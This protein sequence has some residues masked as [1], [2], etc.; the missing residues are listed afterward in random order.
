MLILLHGDRRSSDR[1]LAC[2]MGK[3]VQFSNKKSID[4]EAMIP[5][6]YHQAMFHTLECM[7][8]SLTIGRLGEPPVGACSRCAIAVVKIFLCRLPMQRRRSESSQKNSKEKFRM[9]M[10]GPTRTNCTIHFL[11]C[12]RMIKVKMSTQFRL[13]HRYRSRMLIMARARAP[14]RNHQFKPHPDFRVPGYFR[15]LCRRPLILP[16]FR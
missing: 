12:P 15:P 4:I 10:A 16:S 11:I 14:I 9:P 1:V 2:V 6:G 8:L 13:A 7:R 5:A 3:L